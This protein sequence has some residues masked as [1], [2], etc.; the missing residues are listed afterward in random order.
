MPSAFIHEKFVEE[1]LQNALKTGVI[2]KAL[3]EEIHL[4]LPLGVVDN[5]KKLRLIWDG[6]YLN[7]TLEEKP[8]LMETLH[9]EG[10]GI[11]AGGTHGFLIDLKSAFYSIT[12]DPDCQPFLGFH[13]NNQGYVFQ[14]LPFGVSCAPWLLNLLLKQ[15]LRHWRSECGIYVLVY[16]DDSTGRG[17]SW[18]EARNAAIKIMSDLEALGFLIQHEKTVGVSEP[19][20]QLKVLGTIV[21]LEKQT[22]NTTPA[23][24]AK[25]FSALEVLGES[26][27]QKKFQVRQVSRLAGLLI[28]SGISL[29][30]ATRIRTRSLH[31]V[32]DS[33]LRRDALGKLE[34]DPS[35]PRTWDRHVR[36]SPEARNEIRWWQNNL[37]KQDGQS[38]MFN[39]PKLQAEGIFCADASGTGWGS[40]LFLNPLN[41]E[42]TSSI[43]WERMRGYFPPF[44]TYTD[45][46]EFIKQGRA[47]LSVWGGLD[48]QQR[49]K[50]STWRELYGLQQGLERFREMVQETRIH[51]C[52]DSQTGVIILGGEVPRYAWKLLGGSSKPEIQKLAIKILDLEETCQVEATTS[53]IPRN[54][55]QYADCLSHYNEYRAHYDF[56]LHPQKFEELERTFGPHTF[57]RMATTETAKCRKFCSAWFEPTCQWVDAFSSLWDPRENNYCF[58]SPRLA[59]KTIAHIIASRVCATIVLMNWKGAPFWPMLFPNGTHNRAAEWVRDQMLLGPA[60]DILSYPASFAASHRQNLPKGSVLAFRLDCR[61]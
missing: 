42:A 49:Q 12:M 16:M 18:T 45:L 3:P 41:E 25:I 1:A 30:K 13:W 59:S 29:G 38:I 24:K 14:Q 10:R 21:D 32:V 37:E 34:E 36:L 47:N 55:N 20:K 6:R 15:P 56:Q 23:R 27:A 54:W 60:E 22:F 57:D 61:V 43:L 31:G 7:E 44:E 51:K 19:A 50:S 52:L 39:P 58:P 40:H 35:N 48:P 8:F 11:F 2:R 26:P 53:W 9:R 4:S 28:S 17:T 5:G 46:E 33:R